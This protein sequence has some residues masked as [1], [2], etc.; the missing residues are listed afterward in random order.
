MPLIEL[1]PEDAKNAQNLDD[2][3]FGDNNIKIEIPFNSLM[4]VF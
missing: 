2:G 3:T 4:T 1:D